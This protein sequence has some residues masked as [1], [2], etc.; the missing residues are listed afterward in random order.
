[1]HFHMTIQILLGFYTLTKIGYIIHPK[2]YSIQNFSI[3][4]IYFKL[5]F[6]FNWSYN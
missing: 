3:T 4:L 2:L 1:M 5:S 6:F